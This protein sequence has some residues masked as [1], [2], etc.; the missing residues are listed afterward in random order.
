[1]SDILMPA[2]SNKAANRNAANNLFKRN[3]SM[4]H[5]QI[6]APLLRQL[7]RAR[8]LR[9]KSVRQNHSSLRLISE[10]LPASQP[11]SNATTRYFDKL[12]CAKAT[13]VM[14]CQDHGKI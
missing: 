2:I 8:L 1:M 12:L 3:S 14:N 6:R 10:I 7:Q 5:S 13:F 4:R 11:L 9:Q